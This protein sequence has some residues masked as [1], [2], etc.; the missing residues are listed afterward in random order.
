MLPISARFNTFEKVQA[1]KLH[2]C[3]VDGCDGGEYHVDEGARAVLSHHYGYLE[4]E[5]LYISLYSRLVQPDKPLDGFDL[6]TR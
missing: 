4:F 2:R 3:D 5:F 1:D 6:G